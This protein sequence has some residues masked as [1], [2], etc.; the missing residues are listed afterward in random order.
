MSSTAAAG[1]SRCQRP[2]PQGQGRLPG[3]EGEAEGHRHPQTVK[4]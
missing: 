3:K 4:E 2:W 1:G